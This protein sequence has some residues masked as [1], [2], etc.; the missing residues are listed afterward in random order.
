MR[1]F[2]ASNMPTDYP[3]K[4]Q[5][6]STVSDRVRDTAEH[7]ILDSGIGD[8]VD[9]VEL[10]DLAA[11]Y[12]PDYVVAKDELHE[13]EE[14]IANTVELLDRIGSA[15]TDAEVLVPLQPPYDEHY[16]KL[17][18]KGITGHKYVLGGMA[19]DSV[20]TAQ[21]LEWIHSFREVA[22]D[23]YAHGLGIGGGIEMVEALA[24]K[25]ILDSIDCAT[26]EMAAINGCVLDTRLRQNEVMA[27]SGGEGRCNRSY[28]LADFNSW[29][30]RDVW[31]N[32]SKKSHDLSA[33]S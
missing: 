33:Y 14:T 6:P 28:P 15:Q 1:V 8:D 7:F 29:Q 11:S 18:E 5:K 24:G 27:F 4:L 25:D 19:I 22:P 12:D 31:V 10:L 20:D 2:V 3:W 30:L 23:V 9:T 13:H 17:R 21:A 26:P 32:E 16:E